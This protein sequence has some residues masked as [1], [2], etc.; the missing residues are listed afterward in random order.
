MK[1]FNLLILEDEPIALENLK[2]SIQT[3]FDDFQILCAATVLEAKQVIARGAF[4][5]A[6]IDINLNDDSVDGI[7]LA[8]EVVKVNKRAEILFISAYSDN[9]TLE[10]AQSVEPMCFITKPI[11]ESQVSVAI[12]YFIGASQKY[13]LLE[14]LSK[15]EIQIAEFISNGLNNKAISEKLNLS[16]KTIH[17]YKARAFAKLGI[18]SV[19]ELVRLIQK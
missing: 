4:D 7:D 14:K 1:K 9:K 18:N 3:E 13:N 2:S 12:R 5:L 6:I 8:K 19:A 17:S 11:N 10:R 15:R 16:E